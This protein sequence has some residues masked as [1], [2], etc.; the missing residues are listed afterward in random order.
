MKLYKKE[1]RAVWEEVGDQHFKM[2]RYP[3]SE[4][5]DEDKEEELKEKYKP[6]PDVWC[7][8]EI[9]SRYV[10]VKEDWRNRDGSSF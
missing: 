10:P 1:I 3:V 9:E 7:L 2:R 8:L 5:V 6:G 4:W